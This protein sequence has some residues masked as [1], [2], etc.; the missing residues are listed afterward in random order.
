MTNSFYKRL[1]M[2]GIAGLTLSVAM[3]YSTPFYRITKAAAKKVRKRMSV[4]VF[5]KTS[6]LNTDICFSDE[7]H[8][9]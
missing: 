2:L 5:N 1:E 9:S 3:V 6:F 8:V 4:V 7:F